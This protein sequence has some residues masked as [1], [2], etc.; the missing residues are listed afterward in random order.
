[1]VIKTLN[2][3][4]P[5]SDYGQLI[6]GKRFAGRK[7]E[8]QAIR[9]RVIGESFGNIAVMGMPRVGKSNLAFQALMTLKEEQFAKRNI[10]IFVYVGKFSS[11][12]DFFKHLTSSVL[13][14][15]KQNVTDENVEL[16]NKLKNK[17]EDIKSSIIDRY[18][19]NEN[20]ERFFKLLHRYNY[21]A[22]YILDEFDRAV[23]LFS[24][25]DFQNLRNISSQVEWKICIVT[26]SRRT[27]Q[28]IELQNGAISSL[29]GVFSDL[30]LGL[31]SKEDFNEY[32]HIVKSFE[33]EISEDYKRQVKYLVG[34]HPFL[35]DLYNY[36]AC[37]LISNQKEV[38]S[39]S[40]SL[41]IE[42]E[43][44]LNLYDNFEKVLKLMKEEGL[45][46]KAIQLILGPVFDV[47]P[48]DEQKLLKYQFI[49]LVDN[50]EKI[51][52][53]KQDLGIKKDNSKHS[54]VC[55]S[56]YFTELINLKF[57]EIDYWPLWNQTE[58]NVREI[59]K[60]Y[61]S[62]TFGENWELAYLKKHEKSE[63]K[64]KGIQKLD[65][66]RSSTKNKFGLLASSHLIDYTF[67]RDMYDLFI[68][69]DWTWFEKVFGETKNEW[70]KRFNTLA[71]IRN[72]IAHNN[73][74][75]I[76]SEELKNAKKYCE[77]IINRISQFKER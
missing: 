58:K 38:S 54:Y 69:S 46:S 34:H 71:E 9:N 45:Y 75:F 17:Y 77:I 3:Q 1:M 76:S 5:F 16:I 65:E 60:E 39:D 28:E 11:S 50:S 6:K 29:S 48:I 37:N 40:L 26:L 8:I 12:L 21:R 72:P 23:D 47:T 7:Q 10:I 4:N 36:E 55:F 43:L 74:E 32:W 2:T 42:S 64:I 56:D 53:L 20:I 73:S 67:P 49:R 66:V 27:I 18:E 15:L 30:R 13:E 63:G 31:F 68:S 57:N 25:A 52:I 61:I 35:I 59:I 22:T 62:E 14:D 19:F 33:I 24:E 44:K 41:K 70:G 51:K